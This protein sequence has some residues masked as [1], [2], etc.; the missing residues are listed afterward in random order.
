MP[1][2]A[3]PP[4]NGFSLVEL[5]VALF[6]LGLLASVAVLALPGDRQA[7]RR[8]ATRF[9]LRAGAA[10]DAAITGGA[11]VAVIVDPAGYR[12]ERRAGAAWAPLPDTVFADERW[13]RGTVV[14]TGSAR[15][16]GRR[17]V[18]DEVGLAAGDAA[19]DLARGAEQ[20]RVRLARDGRV[21]V[22]A[23]R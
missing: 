18:F 9:A 8:E 16:E 5:M 15:G 14:R 7:L 3:S 20:V 22:D 19:V 1:H 6:V 21:S 23:A 11:P 12:F 13:G 10:R 2:R 17:V 4:A